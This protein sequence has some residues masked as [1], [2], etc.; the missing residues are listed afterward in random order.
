[1]SLQDESLGEQAKDVLAFVGVGTY[2][3]G[4]GTYLRLRGKIK[5]GYSFLTIC[6]STVLARAYQALGT[7]SSGPL[8]DITHLDGHAYRAR[9]PVF[10]TDMFGRSKVRIYEDGVELGEAH[11]GHSEIVELGQGRYSHWG[12]GTSREGLL[13]LRN[14][15][16][17]WFSSSDNT[18]PR[19]NGRRYTYH[20]S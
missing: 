7:P 20:A 10:E 17:L 15:S 14:F 1:M 11:V 9:I 18:D 3:A 4:V 16:T 12:I 8:E 13:R 2:L 19:T 5:P 6:R